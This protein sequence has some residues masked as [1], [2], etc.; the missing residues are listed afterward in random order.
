MGFWLPNASVR[1]RDTVTLS[2]RLVQDLCKLTSENPA[3]SGIRNGVIDLHFEVVIPKT[4]SQA[5][6]VDDSCKHCYFMNSLQP[7]ATDSTDSM[8]TCMHKHFLLWIEHEIFS[9]DHSR[10]RHSPPL[11]LLSSRSTTLLPRLTVPRR[12]L[13]HTII[14]SL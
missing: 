3:G 9:L 14:V 4:V 11:H 8:Y 5:N 2:L 1:H 10:H 6:R 12:T 13:W 7:L